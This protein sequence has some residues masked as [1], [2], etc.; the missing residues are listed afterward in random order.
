[1][2]SYHSYGP[3]FS[4]FAVE[5]VVRQDAATARMAEHAGLSAV[6]GMSMKAEDLKIDVLGSVGIATFILNYGFDTETERVEKKAR[7]TLVFVKDEGAW[8]VIHEH[9]SDY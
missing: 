2:D 3:K 9:F 4:K 8:K 1:L 5:S 6:T 7:S